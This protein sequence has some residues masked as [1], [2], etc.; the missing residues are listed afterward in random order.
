VFIFF[1]RAKENEP[2][3]T[4]PAPLAYKKHGLPSSLLKNRA[5]AELVQTTHSNILAEDSLFLT[6]SSAQSKGNE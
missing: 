2:K 4:R 5:A 3:E 6:H 1:A